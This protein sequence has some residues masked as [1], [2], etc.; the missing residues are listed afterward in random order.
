MKRI[1]SANRAIDL[2]GAGKDGFQ[3]A[4]PGVHPATELTEKWFNHVQEAIVRTIEAAGAAPSEADYDQ[5]T[6]SVISLITSRINA[7]V[8]A[9]PGALDT[10]KEL[11]DALGNDANFAATMTAQ[12]AG[13]ES[14]FPSGTRMLFQQTAAPVGWTK[15]VTHNDKLLRVVSGAAGSGGSLAFSA[16]FVNGTTGNHTLTVDEIPPHTHAAVRANI[17]FVDYDDGSGVQ[18][19]EGQSGSTGGGQP[20]NHPLNLDVQYVDIIIASKD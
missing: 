8:N 7:L 5:F 14:R 13:K 10:L 2:F 20:H 1:D 6:N 12:L 15:V 3:A 4:L 16:A 9:A 18:V 17:N 19:G 11:A